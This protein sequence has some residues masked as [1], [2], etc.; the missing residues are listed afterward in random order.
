MRGQDVKKGFGLVLKKWR[1]R[2]DSS[3]EELAWRAD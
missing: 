1:Y 2:A 3:Q